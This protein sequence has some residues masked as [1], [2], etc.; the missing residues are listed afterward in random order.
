MKSLEPENTRP[1]SRGMSLIEVAIALGIISFCFVSIMGL[2]PT[3]LSAVRASREKTLSQRMYQTVAEDLHENP[4]VAGSNR[5]YSFDAEG[6]LLGIT[7]ARAGQTFRNSALPG[8]TL[9]YSGFASN[10]TPTTL[11]G[12]PV[13]SLLILSTIAI[14]D[15]VRKTNILERPIWTTFSD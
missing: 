11:P 8:A 4:I 10:N 12:S 6:F 13:N 14:T 7:P 3:M 2:F 5:E 15:T 1:R 9:R